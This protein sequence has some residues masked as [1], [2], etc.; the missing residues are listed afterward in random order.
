[1]VKRQ[2]LEKQSLGVWKMYSMN[3][4][5]TN[6]NFGS[7]LEYYFTCPALRLIYWFVLVDTQATPLNTGPGVANNNLVTY[8]RI[9][10]NSNNRAIW[11][12]FKLVTPK[13]QQLNKNYIICKI[14]SPLKVP[15]GK[16]Q[17]LIIVHDSSAEGFIPNHLY[18][19]LV[20]Q[21]IITRRSTERDS[22]NDLKIS[23][24]LIFQFGP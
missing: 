6:I 7:Y 16:G 22:E 13:I 20:L 21:M 8:S 9:I 19:R 18:F 23:F 24:S 17:H 2:L 1:M 5:K 12:M 3:M 11:E 4:L 14:D 10:Y 15:L